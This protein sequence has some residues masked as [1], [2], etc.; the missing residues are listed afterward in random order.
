MGFNEV[1]AHL[2]ALL[3][4]LSRDYRLEE[5]E[6]PRFIPGRAGSVL[7]GERRVGVIGEIRPEVLESFGIQM[8]CAAVELDV[9]LLMEE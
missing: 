6:D 8:P 3:Y 5:V 1:S 9:D 7:C 2:A 4:Y